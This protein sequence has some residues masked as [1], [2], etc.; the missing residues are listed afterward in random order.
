MY[1]C[2]KCGTEMYLLELTSYPP[3]QYYYC[4]SCGYRSRQI[5]DSTKDPVLPKELWVE[6]DS[7]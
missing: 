5:N 1:K 7:K 6:E 4:M 3:K 2:P